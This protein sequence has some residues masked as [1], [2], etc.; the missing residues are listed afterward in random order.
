VATGLSTADVH[1]FAA[2]FPFGNIVQGRGAK[3]AEGDYSPSFELAM[4]RKDVRL[5]L[6][7]TG[8]QPMSALPSI[9]ARMDTL[10]AE[11][12]GALDFGVIAKESAPKRST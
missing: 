4:A 1:A 10:L 8:T 6:E 3:M 11:G 9:A 5:M 7:A 12:H 2:A